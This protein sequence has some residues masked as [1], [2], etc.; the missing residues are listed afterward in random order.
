METQLAKITSTKSKQPGETC[1]TKPKGSL[2]DNLAKEK[3]AG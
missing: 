3:N 2:S 1:S